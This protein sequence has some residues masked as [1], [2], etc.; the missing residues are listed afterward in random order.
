[1]PP[2]QNFSP[3]H[4]SPSLGIEGSLA[5]QASAPLV[6]R[7][8]CS[9]VTQ[10][11]NFPLGAVLGMKQDKFSQMHVCRV[12][13]CIQASTSC[14]GGHSCLWDQ[15]V[16]LWGASWWIH[17]NHDRVAMSHWRS[18]SLSMSTLWRVGL[19][20]I[21]GRMSSRILLY[22]VITICHSTSHVYNNLPESTD[23]YP[24]QALL[25]LSLVKGTW[26]FGQAWLSCH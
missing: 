20:G 4:M 24:M 9:M 15:C 3:A 2:L 7:L 1:M 25:H 26:H 12:L 23:Y 17:L 5:L 16:H 21:Q 22:C 6:Q 13:W 11:L 8:Q 19:A 10:P 14:G 18:R